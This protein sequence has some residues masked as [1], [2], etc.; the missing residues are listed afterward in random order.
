MAT[1]AL[2]PLVIDWRHTAAALE[3]YSKAVAAAYK[4]ELLGDDRI[5]TGKLIQSVRTEV[6]RD[7]NRWQVTLD[8][9]AYW[10]YV[11]YDTRPHWPPPAAIRAWIDAKPVL[12]RP[13]RNGKLPTPEQLTFL[14]GRK[15]AREGTDGSHTLRNTLEELNEEWMDRITAALAADAGD[16]ATALFADF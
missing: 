15:I 5:A 8:V 7:G 3:G 13:D 4:E 12:P 1:D 6:V 9:A 11:E 16:L 10:K 14:I 2:I